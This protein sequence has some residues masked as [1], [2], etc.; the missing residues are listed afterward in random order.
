MVGDSDSSVLSITH[1][2]TP[3]PIMASL[4]KNLF[5]VLSPLARERGCSEKLAIGTLVGFAAVL[6]LYT[7]CVLAIPF[8]VQGPTLR[9]TVR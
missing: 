8:I 6:L 1:R 5:H 7:Y 3:P 2:R 4:P 9:D